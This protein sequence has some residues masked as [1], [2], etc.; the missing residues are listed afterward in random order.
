MPELN[1]GLV[2]QDICK[3]ETPEDADEK[4]TRFAVVR[5]T[6]YDYLI[7]SDLW[8]RSVREGEQLV[9]K[10]MEQVSVEL[11]RPVSRASVSTPSRS[12]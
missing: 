6:K 7:T 11:M 4:F 5:A 9:I 2:W 10:T 3:E 8:D 1:Y 12:C